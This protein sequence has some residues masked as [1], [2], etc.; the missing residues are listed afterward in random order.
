[1]RSASPAP[2]CEKTRGEDRTNHTMIAPSLQR[3]WSWRGGV[4]NRPARAQS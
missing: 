2:R 3:C 4:P 1:M